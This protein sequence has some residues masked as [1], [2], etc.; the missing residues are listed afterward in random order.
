MG[1][2][3][4]SAPQAVPIAFASDFLPRLL[5]Q[6]EHD[7]Q[8]RGCVN[9]TLAPRPPP[10]WLEAAANP[11]GARLLGPGRR[12]RPDGR[13]TEPW[14]AGSVGEGRGA[15]PWWA[16]PGGRSG[17]LSPNWLGLLGRGGMLSPGGRGPAGRA[18]AGSAGRQ[19]AEPA[20]V[21]AEEGRAGLGARRG[22]S[23]GLGVEIREPLRT[24]KARYKARRA[25][26]PQP[27]LLEAA[28]CVSGL[29]HRLRGRLGHLSWTDPV[30]SPGSAIDWPGTGIYHIYIIV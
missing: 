25:R 28:G 24:P 12:E 29:H 6:N 14:W 1:P 10:T 7:S 27:L 3:G 16:G 26:E 23:A 19:R 20:G 2:V 17:A 22:G 5:S 13:G 8:L 30:S 21:S 18:A 9:V 15:E 11:A 4:P